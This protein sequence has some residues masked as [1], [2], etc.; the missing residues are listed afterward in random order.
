MASQCN[1]IERNAQVRESVLHRISHTQGSSQ[2]CADLS[3]DVNLSAQV[4]AMQ[5]VKW[6]ASINIDSIEGENK[7]EV[8][9]ELDEMQMPVG[10]KWAEM[11]PGKVTV[12]C[13]MIC[14]LMSTY[15]HRAKQ[16][17]ECSVPGLRK[18]CGNE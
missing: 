15:Q 1:A 16:F 13:V 18:R 4:N 5:N 6:L 2:I 7:P 11:S 14:R 8:Q 3:T 9:C 10:R 12:K 17:T